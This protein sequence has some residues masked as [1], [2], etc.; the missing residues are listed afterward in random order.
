[1]EGAGNVQPSPPPKDKA[2]FFAFT[3]KICLPHKSVTSYVSGK[4]PSKKNP[5]SAP[6][7]DSDLPDYIDK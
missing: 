6:V 7:P 5:V 2:F 3:F 1:M 4:S